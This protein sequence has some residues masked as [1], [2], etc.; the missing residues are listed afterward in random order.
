MPKKAHSSDVFLT[1]RR[2]GWNEDAQNFNRRQT[3]YRKGNQV[4]RVGTG[5]EGRI[6]WCDRYRRGR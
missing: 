5:R 4:I 1:S 6:V 2:E 3:T